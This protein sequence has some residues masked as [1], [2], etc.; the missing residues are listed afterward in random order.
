M[1]LVFS[2]K[3]ILERVALVER[4]QPGP[5]PQKPMRVGT[6]AGGVGFRAATV[7][8]LLDGDVLGVGF[9]GGQLGSLLRDCLDRQDVPH[10]LTP[11]QAGTHGSFLLLDKEQGIISDVPEPTPPHTP[12][13][14]EA[15]L[16]TLNRHLPG[17]SL[18]LAA[19]DGQNE[20]ADTA[21]F[22]EAFAAARKRDVP[23][24]VDGTG[25]ALEAALDGGAWLLRL[26]LR[27]L[28]RR[29]ERSMQHDS[30][31]ITEAQS[32]QEK[33]I[34]NVV[35]TLGDEGAILVAENGAW[36]VKPPVVSHFNPTGSGAALS[37]ALAARWVQDG[38]LLEAVRY[39]CAA[40]SVNVTYDEPGY[41]T[42]GEVKILLRQTIAEPITQRGT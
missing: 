33:S 40:A 9:V 32:F 16:K 36:R 35:I 6:Y 24:L 29:T 31:I 1:I 23:I 11:M 39:G 13:E 42:A 38:N 25:A 20:E 21:L 2:P 15:L 27:T 22:R 37:G 10:L 26:G 19:D 17:A 5:G 30:A 3:P 34:R 14:A 28:Q 12:A 41:A 18:L 4:F 7:A 8:R